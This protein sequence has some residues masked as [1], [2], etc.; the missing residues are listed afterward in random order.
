M[1]RRFLRTVT[2]FCCLILLRTVIAFSQHRDNSPLIIQISG[3]KQASGSGLENQTASQ[4]KQLQVLNNSTQVMNTT[5]VQ[6][7]VV[8]GP[9]TVDITA[10][11]TL[12]GSGSGSIIARASGGTPPYTYSLDGGTA[13][14]NG[15]FV[16]LSPG[17][18]TLTITDATGHTES[19]TVTVSNTYNPP[20]ATVGYLKDALGCTSSDASATVSASG[21]TPPYTYSWDRI[22]YQSNPVFNNLAPGHYVFAVKDANGC[23]GSGISPF[24]WLHAA[25]GCEPSSSGGS[26]SASTCFSTG[27][28]SFTAAGQ[29]PPFTYS[30]DQVNWQATGNFSNLSSGLHKIYFKDSKGNMAMFSVYIAQSCY[31]VLNTQ[32]V[33]ADCKGTNGRATITVSNANPPLQYSIDGINFSSS[34][35][36]TNLR[37]G[38]YLVAVKDAAGEIGYDEFTIEENCPELTLTSIDETC[39]NTNG[40]IT[41]TATKGVPPYSYSIDGVNFQPGNVFNNLGSGSYT[42]TVKDAAGNTATAAANLLNHCILIDYTAQGPA[43]GKN[44]GWV[45]IRPRGGTAPY[46]YSLTGISYQSQNRFTGLIPGNHTIYVKD[47]TGAIATSALPLKEMP[48]PGLTLQHTPA[49]CALPSASVLIIASGGTPPYQY[50]LDRVYWS[51]SG[52]F[53]NLPPNQIY[54]AYVKDINGCITQQGFATTIK[55]L[56]LTLMVI[57]ANCNTGSGSIRA[58]ASDGQPPYLF[59]IDGVNYQGSQDFTGL[60]PNTYTIYVKDQAGDTKQANVQVTNTCPTPQIT[61]TDESCSKGN[62]SISFTGSGGTAPYTYSLSAGN[63][64]SVSSFNN[65]SAGTYRLYIKDAAGYINSIPFTIT[66]TAGPGLQYISAAASCNNNDGSITIN[67]TGNGPFMYKLNQSAFQASPVF[68]NVASGDHHALVQDARG[69]E[70]TGHPVVALNNDLTL[71]A[72]SDH[73]ICEGSYVILAA[74]SNASQFSWT[75]DHIDNASALQ[76]T[77]RPVTSTRYQITATKGPCTIQDDVLVG[78]DPAPIAQAGPAPVICFGKDAILQGSGGV[79]YQWTPSIGLSD[80]RSASPIVQKPTKSITYRLRVTGNNHCSSL[81]EATVTVTVTPPPRIDAGPDLLLA[82]NQPHALKVVDVNNSG[83]SSY[84]WQPAE[85][86]SNPYIANPIVSLN[87]STTYTIRAVT[88]AGCEGL[89]KLNIKVNDG[90]DIYVPNAFTPNHDGKNDLLK[91]I[92]VGIKT[93]KYFS[94]FNRYGQRIFHTTDPGKGWDGSINAGEQGTNTFVWMAEGIDFN[95]GVVQRKGTV[96][97]LR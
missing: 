60:F 22:N 9:F 97:L 29:F 34:N 66:N 19:T 81:N 5:P 54:N 55:C 39:G 27:S 88:A 44:N 67:A 68:Y 6:Q 41:A 35:V 3:N 90:P 93:F 36:F 8:M 28:I 33:K 65:L 20:T 71:D 69:C 26:Y 13:Y 76:P 64:Q 59:S 16:R 92:P 82:R 56:Q 77:V 75:G 91:A 87:R 74:H 83:F 32:T 45:E 52:D 23:L 43:C 1:N 73:L 31:P 70:T 30:L 72:G 61:I 14:S 2:V 94:V 53:R 46:Q 58:T 18:H 50:S 37:P 4:I 40:S 79:L 42:I 80:A 21:G 95:G 17:L 51:S 12:C 57:P 84:N 62:G 78:V 25:A 7:L 15:W 89:G 63:F 38:T 24:A 96:M 49:T 86:L 47:A 48:P 11:G 85:G 10:T